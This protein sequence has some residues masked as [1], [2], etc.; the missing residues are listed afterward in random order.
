[1]DISGVMMSSN[2]L[3]YELLTWRIT[4]EQGIW[5][6]EKIISSWEEFRVNFIYSCYVMA[7]LQERPQTFIEELETPGNTA[8]FDE[9]GVFQVPDA[10]LKEWD[11]EEED[12]DED[13]D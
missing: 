1:M 8:H 13:D 6:D 4:T 9:N 11:L 5:D 2:L 12:D 7:I 10:K 3:V